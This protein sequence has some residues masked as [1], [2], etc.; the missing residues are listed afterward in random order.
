MNTFL[1]ALITGFFVTALAVII[2]ISIKGGE[3]K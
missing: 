1:E 3:E 2:F